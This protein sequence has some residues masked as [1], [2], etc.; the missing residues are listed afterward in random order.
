MDF[1]IPSQLIIYSFEF[2]NLQNHL[3]LVFLKYINLLVYTE[4]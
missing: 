1:K 4:A 3:G 2:S